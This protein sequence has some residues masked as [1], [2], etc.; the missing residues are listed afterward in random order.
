MKKRIALLLVGLLLFGCLTAGCAEG[1]LILDNP[2]L[3][4]WAVNYGAM[5]LLMQEQGIPM[6]S[7]G[8][9][10]SISY[11]EKN[12]RT[13]ANGE[14]VADGGAYSKQGTYM[15]GMGAGV[16]QEDLWYV[17][18]TFNAGADK[19]QCANNVFCMLYAFDDLRETLSASE[20]DGLLQ[21]MINML[22]GDNGTFGI[23]L[24]GKIIMRKELGNGQV[25]IGVDSIPFYEAFYAGSLT[26]YYNLDE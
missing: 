25:I 23:Q 17:T 11:Y 16:D 20:N 19:D 8:V 4:G 9:N 15:L 7:H 2:V 3:I 24:N 22:V 14:R 26:E 21:E 12:I 10:G 18:M 1:M 5:E 13:G 6:D